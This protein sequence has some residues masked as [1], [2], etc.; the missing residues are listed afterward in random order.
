MRTRGKG[1]V[2]LA[3]RKQ[4]WIARAL[5]TPSQHKEASQL[6]TVHIGASRAERRY[7]VFSDV[8]GYNTCVSCDTCKKLFSAR[9]KDGRT[10]APSGVAHKRS[11]TGPISQ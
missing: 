2:R 6:V 1:E 7:F 11:S 10:L 8:C 4:G 9:W 5:L 3:V